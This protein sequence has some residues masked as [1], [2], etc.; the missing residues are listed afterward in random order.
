MVRRIIAVAAL[1]AVAAAAIAV[2]AISSFHPAASR[3]SNGNYNQSFCLNAAPN[4]TAMRLAISSGVTCFR[5]DIALTAADEGYVSNVTKDGGSVL[6]ILDYETVGAQPSPNG[7]TG[8]C[9]WS[10][11][12]WNA[13]VYNALS[14]YPE[15][16][17]WEIWNE[18]LVPNFASGY[19][20]ASA[21]DYYEMIKS[22]YAIIKSRE[23]NSTIVCF[24]GAQ[25]FP[26][27][28]VRYE[29]QF[30]SKVWA[31]GA[32][33]YC[34]AIS[35]HSYSQPY[36]NTSQQAEYGMTLGQE[37][38]LTLNA[39]E[40]LTGKPI[41]VTETGYAS[42]G[43]T[44]SNQLQASALRQSMDFLSQYGFVRRI[45]WFHL[46]GSS[47]AADFGLLN[48]KTLQ[49]KPA[50]YSFMYFARNESS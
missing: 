36:Y 15:V 16:N 5:T 27:G 31:Y 34:D 50:W 25:L 37:L 20:N 46:A 10:L 41:W 26:M 8:V 19:E 48:P 33:R 45:Y 29:Y 12:D 24:G 39:Y 44:L 32:S 38:N 9:N 30:Y 28:A 7:C 22:A 35:V 6:G 42:N 47:G 3:S 21:L 1:V 18:P 4:M 49:P 23:P 14:E 17:E 13:S 11:N 2:L 40:N 43:S